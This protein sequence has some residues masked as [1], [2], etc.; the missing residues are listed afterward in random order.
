M[1]N[2][3]QPVGFVPYLV[4]GRAPQA[5][6]FH[7]YLIRQADT[8]AYRVGDAVVGT[9][10]AD[11]S[12]IGGV[13]MA[14]GTGAVRGVIA[15]V[16]PAAPN[17]PY[18][19]DFRKLIVP[20]TKTRDYYVWVLDAADAQYTIQDDGLNAGNTIAT[21]VGKSCNF[22][23][24]LTT[25]DQTSTTVLTSSNFGSGAAVK[26]LGLAPGSSFGAYAT[27]VVKFASP[28]LGGSSSGGGAS[29]G[30]ATPQALG[31][32]AA[33]SAVAAS[34][35]DHVHTM[36]TAA[37]VGAAALATSQSFTKGQAVTSVALTDAATVAIDASL[38]NNFTLLATSGVGNTRQLGNPTNLKDGQVITVKYKQDA[39]GNRDLTYASKYKWAS[40]TP[41]TLI[42]TANA[43]NL[44]GFTYFADDDI[45]IGS[46]I[47]G[48]A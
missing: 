2:T 10:D 47:V 35:E 8:N 44:I 48:A 36:P 46:A 17:A 4:G 12:G 28:E 19:G 1:P 21:N 43:I 14:S 34:H 29:V 15:A 6:D 11:T 27:W 18:G 45:L 38:S 16:D 32:A 3:A 5:S 33:G 23:N 24:N 20:A 41:P 37:Q 25:A 31:S 30:S 7:R 26:V 9:N 13:T 39:T 22:T 40:G 42:K